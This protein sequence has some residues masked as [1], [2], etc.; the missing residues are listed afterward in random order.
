MPQD[1]E[2]AGATTLWRFGFQSL[3]LPLILH[4]S[5]EAVKI[6]LNS[7]SSVARFSLFAKTSHLW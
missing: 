3:Y 6:I 5:K 1:P 4:R 2:E 7:V